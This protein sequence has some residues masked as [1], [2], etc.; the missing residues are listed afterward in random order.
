MKLALV[1]ELVTES[2]V[3]GTVWR[4]DFKFSTDTIGVNRMVS[5]ERDGKFFFS[6]SVGQNV[7]PLA[8]VHKKAR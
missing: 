7:P 8:S 5:W 3:W 2:K 4:A 6:S 1:I